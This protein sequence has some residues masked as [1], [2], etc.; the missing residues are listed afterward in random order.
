MCVLARHKIKRAG[1][2]AFKKIAVFL[3]SLQATCALEAALPAL[4]PK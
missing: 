4:S 1:D 3:I 2:S